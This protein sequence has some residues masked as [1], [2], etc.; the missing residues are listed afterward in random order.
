MSGIQAD[1]KLIVGKTFTGRVIESIFPNL[2]H[3]LHLVAKTI[4]RLYPGVNELI[5]D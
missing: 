4:R 2:L 3:A 5:V 1:S